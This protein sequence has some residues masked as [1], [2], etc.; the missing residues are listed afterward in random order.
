MTQSNT[1]P[2]ITVRDALRD[3][4]A[5]EMRRDSTVYLM[6]EEVAEYQ[7]AYKISQGLLQEFGP[8]RIIDT[9]ITEHGFAGLNVGAAFL[10]LKPIVE[11]MTFNF[12]MQAID[13]IINS[14]AKTRYMSGGQMECSI[15]FRGPN[16][17]ASRVGAQHSQC[18]ASWY[19]HCPGLKVVS[20]YSAA[21]AKGLLKS[22]IRDPNPVI[23]LEH[24]LMYGHSFDAP[25]DADHIVPIGKASIIR[26]G[27]DVTI[28]SFSMGV[29][30][31][32][33]AADQLAALGIDAEVIDLRTIRP[34]DTETIIN[35]VKKTNRLVSVEEGWPFAGI[36]SEICTM[37][38][39]K[40]FDYLDA[41]PV[42]VASEDVPMPYAANLEKLVL[43]NAEKIINAVKTV[44]YKN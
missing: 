16:G 31:A 18:Y 19:A 44:C 40:A 37:I 1:T 23:F 7:G 27:R 4:M 20:P 26:P 17:A 6:G 36:G 8:K 38:C 39:E 15:V 10:G 29:M 11:F 2:Q 42:R 35:S 22:A 30:H 13:H 24:E 41:P 32:L 33:A 9:P 12:S 21:D 5:E 14:A 28:T 34:L 25:T 43:P 3:A